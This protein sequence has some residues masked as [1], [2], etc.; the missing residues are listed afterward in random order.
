MQFEGKKIYQ[1]WEGNTFLAKENIFKMKWIR[2]EDT[3]IN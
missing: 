2:K 1:E 3:D